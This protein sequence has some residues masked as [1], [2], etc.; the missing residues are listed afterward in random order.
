MKNFISYNRS[1]LYLIALALSLLYVLPITISNFYYI[2]D[3]SRS[4][5]GYARWIDNGRPLAEYI[6]VSM[7]MGNVIDIA[8]IP[9]LLSSIVI[10]TSCYYLCFILGAKG[11]FSPLI[12]SLAVLCSPFYIQNFSYRFDAFTMGLSLSCAIMASA[13][14][15]SNKSITAIIKTS[16]LISALLSLYQP[17]INAYIGFVCSV[18]I[19]RSINDTIK[20]S[21]EYILKCVISLVIG[22]LAYK[23]LIAEVFVAG[24]YSV[25]HSE[26]IELSLSSLPVVIKN[27]ESFMYVF[28]TTL[29][30][31]LGWT[32]LITTIP[33]LLLYLLA[34]LFISHNLKNIILKVFLNIIAIFL[35]CFTVFGMMLYLK[36]PIFYPR[37]FIGFTSIMFMIAYGY[38][39]IPW[40]RLKIL[41]SVMI[42]SLFIQ[43]A[44]YGNAL[45]SQREKEEFLFS[46]MAM[47]IID[48]H[49]EVNYIRF[50]GTTPMSPTASIINRSFGI[51]GHIVPSYIRPDWM[52]GAFY[53]GRLGVKVSYAG[54]INLKKAIADGCKN[55]IKKNSIYH[56]IK[57][58]DTLIFDFRKCQ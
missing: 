51:M 52:F 55:P 11:R 15:Y 44:A 45:S 17:S 5:G 50:N 54:D 8:P 26:T 56:I 1:N 30:G 14:A 16:L 24:G 49:Q 18:V 4:V 48:M 20:T 19:I 42:F 35:M 41:P 33:T 39:E 22:L 40:S 6:I 10:T 37:V 7:G 28:K 25:A 2:D 23:L 32:I 47:D 58:N 36:S 21:I 38:S 34:P 57:Q 53:F 46:K 9:L 31:Y 27:Y 3:M 13:T 43:M 29:S 12:I